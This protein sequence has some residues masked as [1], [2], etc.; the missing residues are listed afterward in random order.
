MQMKELAILGGP[1]GAGKTTAAHVFLPWK[2][3]ITEFVNADE[4]PVASR[5]SIQNALVSPPGD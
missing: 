2:L 5:R 3:H 4:S 1:N